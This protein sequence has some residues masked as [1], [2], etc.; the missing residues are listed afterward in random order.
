MTGQ[1]QLSRISE[2]IMTALG[3]QVP[4]G[5]IGI[6]LSGD[7]YQLPPVKDDV[8]YKQPNANT[9]KAKKNGFRLYSWIVEAATVLLTKIK[10]T[11]NLEYITL[12][13]NVRLGQWDET[14]V[15]TINTCYDSSEPAFTNA[16]SSTTTPASDHSLK[17]IVVVRNATVK[18]L[19]ESKM[20]TLTHLYDQQERELPIILYAS[21]ENVRKRQRSTNSKN[22]K[23]AKT[24]QAPRND[25]PITTKELEY[26]HTLPDSQFDR[27][28]CAFF[29]YLGSYILVSQNLG[30]LYGLANGSSARV[31]GWQFPSNTCYKNTLY[32]GIKVQYPYDPDTNLQAQV[33]FILIEL[34]TSSPFP[35]PPNQP[36][37]LP[38]NVIAIPIIK[39]NVKKNIVVPPTVSDRTSL[40]ITIKQI[41]LRQADILTTY[42][43][44]G[45]QF[46]HYIIAETV[47]K[48]FYIAF[49]R[50]KLGLRSIS[51]QLKLTTA[52]TR[53]CIPSKPLKD[54]M[55]HL[56]TLHI[57]TKN[58]FNQTP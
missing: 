35:R 43:I 5:G 17:P 37:N 25:S 50:G 4:F 42:S 14:M 39:H 13:K 51:L 52:F 10:R 7:L 58:E 57:Q 28:M 40:S 41:P 24:A 18:A 36:P 2:C 56:E 15:A 47:P 23:K 53:L 31:V 11:D 29:L 19:Y 3:I 12:Q 34:T 9:S 33:D 21:F 48:Q 49:S 54:H 46:Q 8:L 22:A 27:M 32:K 55:T 16:L 45:S 26:L 30:L 1:R 6:I 20:R 38:Q 44:Q